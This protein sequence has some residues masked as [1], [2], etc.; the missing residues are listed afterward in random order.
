MLTLGDMIAQ[1]DLQHKV[2]KAHEA[3]L[4]VAKQ[5]CARQQRSPATVRD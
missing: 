1:H 2:R 4:H 5:S 3:Q